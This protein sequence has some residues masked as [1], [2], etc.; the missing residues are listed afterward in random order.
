MKERRKWRRYNIAYPVEG[1]E[2]S[3]KNSISLLDISR[4]GIAFTTTEEVC[5]NDKVNLRIFLKNKMF[6]LETI[7]V[8]SNKL[9]NNVYNIGAKFFEPPK[10]FYPTFEKEIEEIVQFHRECNL[11][12]HK[13]LSFKKT[14]KE[15]LRI[16]YPS[17]T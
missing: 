13:N 15:Y 16:S 12:Q 14:S 10:D 7:V 3:I 6:D 1:G 17:E 11:Y 2:G 9:K 8:Y 4:G 5:E